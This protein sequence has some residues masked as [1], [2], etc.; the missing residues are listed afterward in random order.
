VALVTTG[1]AT[2]R[3]I[4]PG[5]TV[6]LPFQEGT[7]TVAHDLSANHN[8]CT[9]GSGMN[10]PLWM[11]AGVDFFTP[12]TGPAVNGAWCSLPA[13]V[14]ISDASA[15]N[16]RTKMW[17]G[18]LRPLNGLTGNPDF[19]VLLASSISNGVGA[20]WMSWNGTQYHAA[21]YG[22]ILAG[23]TP[24]T[25]T[26]DSLVGWHCVSETL[27][28]STDSTVDH[29]YSDGAEVADYTAQGGSSWDNRQ[30]GEFEYVGYAPWLP[31]AWTEDIVSYVLEYPTVLTPSQ[32][33][34]NVMA[35]QQTAF[36]GRGVGS[37]PG[38]NLSSQNQIVCNGD[39]LTH[40]APYGVTA[41]C[42]ELSG[43]DQSFQVTPIAV[44]GQ[45]LMTANSNVPL[46]DAPIFA[47]NAKYNFLSQEAGIDDYLQ[48]VVS[49]RVKG[50]L[51]DQQAG[52]HVLWFTMPSVGQNDAA[53]QQIDSQ[54][55][56]LAPQMGVTLVDDATDPCL[57]AT[58]AYANPAPCSD[59]VDGVHL[60]QAG[61]DSYL[62]SF[63]N[64][65][66]YL[67]GS[68]AAN[69]T[70][71]SVPTYSM[72]A[73]DGYVSVY[74]LGSSTSITLPSCVGFS[75]TTPFVVANTS[76]TAS[77]TVTALAGQTPSQQVNGAS[78]AVSVPNLGILTLISTPLPP[79][80]AGC[81]W[82]A[83]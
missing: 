32:I 49:L 18:Y 68:T 26:P 54:L 17:C 83:Q 81:S 71:V 10:A 20:M 78:A 42:D 65:I 30:A 79:A 80:T 70:S 14:T 47:G 74:P 11:G 72:V 37:L 46:I 34:S 12:N 31:A 62:K 1:Y 4:L 7:G 75:A 56:A 5:A 36:Y 15:T 21:Y 50:A 19:T 69:P 60:S 44:G 64:V 27:G 51:L 59:F 8:D 73:H 3:G 28:S 22:G 77:V 35:L 16:A 58:G 76:E 24:T 29:L 2:V 13:S 6:Q 55:R 41:F 40:G 48:D 33:A 63:V 61:A 39:S 82:T 66:N 38:P 23:S 45:N 43:L 53:V 67:T 52:F 25:S 57:G 9:F